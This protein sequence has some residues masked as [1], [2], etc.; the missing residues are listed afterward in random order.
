ME[1]DYRVAAASSSDMIDVFLTDGSSFIQP[2][3]RRNLF[4]LLLLLCDGSL[5]DLLEG[6]EF[7]IRDLSHYLAQHSIDTGRL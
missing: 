4:G 1:S 3:D 2:L 7:S 5:D 6:S